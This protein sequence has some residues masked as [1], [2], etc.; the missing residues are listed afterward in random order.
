MLL[1]TNPGQVAWVFAFFGMVVVI[2]ML[3]RKSL[4]LLASLAILLMCVVISVGAGSVRIPVARVI[5]VF[6]ERLRW[7][8]TGQ[9]ELTPESVIVWDLRFP[10]ALLAA[11]VGAAL[12]VAGAL[13][14]GFLRNPL[15][16]PYVLGVSAGASVG[17]ALAIM[18]LSGAGWL[19]GLFFTPIFALAGAI[20]AVVLVYLLA[21]SGHRVPVVTLLLS[22]IALNT[23]LS[24]LLSFLIYFSQR[25]LQA[26]IYWLMGSFS[27]RGWLQVAAVLPYLVVGAIMAIWL[28]RDLNA[29]SL[30]E[31]AAATLGVN[32]ER[33]K[34]LLLFASTLLTA[35]AVAVSG[36]IGFIGLLVP[37]VTRILLGPDH[38]LL[39]PAAAIWGAAFLVLADLL[40]RTILPTAE[41]PVGIITSLC[42]GPFFL[43]LLRRKDVRGF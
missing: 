19:S 27:G 10:R 33:V 5:G 32:V 15:A 18:V 7:L 30:G 24:A 17:A 3:R 41:M 26:L 4:I 42:G 11:A 34:L 8:F 28:A 43:F 23:V 13:M 35:G 22:G 16:E 2:S 31:D 14:Q 39:I 1:S 37:H 36:I 38:R 29:L 6:S 12:S 20:L 25:N 40:A 9:L 21:R